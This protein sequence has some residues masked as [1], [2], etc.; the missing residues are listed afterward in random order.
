MSNV[1]GDDPSESRSDV[2]DRVSDCVVALDEDLCYT[3]VNGRAARRLDVDRD[4]V[5]GQHV[6]EVF[7]AA[8]D[9]DAAAAIERAVETGE[10]ASFT[11]YNEER[12]TWFEA[13]VYPDEGGVSLF[14]R[15]VT[16]RRDRREEL[17]RLEMLFENAQDALFVV[18]V[19]EAFRFERVNPAY[20]AVTGLSN[21]T[22]RGKTIDEVFDPGDR[23]AVRERFEQ[24]IARREPLEYEERL[25]VPESDSHWETRIAP[26]V[27]DDAVVQLVGATRNV[28]ERRAR[29]RELERYSRLFEN[30][31]IGV[32]RNTAGPEGRF[33]LVNDAMVDLFDADSKAEL[34]EYAVSDLYADPAEREAFSDRLEAEGV[35]QDHQLELETLEGETL[36]GAVTAIVGDRDGERAFDGA[37]EDITERVEYQQRLEAQRDNLEA[38]N[39][40]VRHDIRNDLQIVLSYV[41]MLED[42]VDADGESYVRTALESVEN[43]IALTKTARDVAEV[44][45]QADADRTPVSLDRALELQLDE[46][47]S[48]HPGAVVTVEGTVPNV[49]VLADD[50]LDSVFRNL[51]KNAVQHND[52][53][54]PEVEVAVTDTDEAIVVRIADNGPGI[55]ADQRQA[56]FGR[57]KKGLESEGSGIGLFLV[58]TL[59]DR[60]GGDVS[61]EDADLGG[62]AFV[63][64]LPRTE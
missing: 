19:D 13:Q 23:A 30:L 16:A 35:V 25:S 17:E 62:V 29:E 26:V 6:W 12:E 5:I 60:Y 42:H 33:T 45:L 40:M 56:V 15:D 10:P 20:E 44:M 47:R 4:A 7:P 43:A 54:V 32:Y 37:I 61:I 18:A 3:Y 51:L 36:W 38:L 58:D 31:P 63:V 39:Q 55:P 2:L 64:R 22:V 46:V 11:R 49:E 53:T 57:G 21:E 14:F 48:A 50:M 34:R 1:S 9:S 52:S 24:C 59:V 8:E 27:V 41:G 28:T